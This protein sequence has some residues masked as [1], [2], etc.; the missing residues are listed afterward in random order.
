MAWMV[1]AAEEYRPSSWAMKLPEPLNLLAK[2][3]ILGNQVIGLLLILQSTAA[4]AIIAIMVKLIY[5]R[6]V[7]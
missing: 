1:A 7:E 5:V 3:S 2:M 6:T 4:N